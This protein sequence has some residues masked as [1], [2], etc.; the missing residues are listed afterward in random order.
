MKTVRVVG[1]WRIKHLLFISLSQSQELHSPK[2]TLL[3]VACKFFLQGNTPS[4][5]LCLQRS[6]KRKISCQGI[7]ATRGYRAAD[8]MEE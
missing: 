7:R 1:F 3:L 6:L 5:L 8:A 4:Y 2:F